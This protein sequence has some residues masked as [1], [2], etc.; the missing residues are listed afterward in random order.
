MTVNLDE[1]IAE[2]ELGDEANRF[3]ESDLYR[4]FKGAAEQEVVKAQEMLGEADPD[5]AKAISDL[6]KHI[7]L[8]KSFDQWLRE[9]IDRG[10]N[11]LEVYRH[12]RNT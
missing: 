6:Q 5:D 2:A 7:R 10:N 1:L 8:Y 4:F 12:A 9:L 3:F 11:A